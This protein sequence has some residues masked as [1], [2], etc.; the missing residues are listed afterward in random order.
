VNKL[1]KPLKTMPKTKEKTHIRLCPGQ[2]NP[3]CRSEL[4]HNRPA[5]IPLLVRLLGCNSLFRK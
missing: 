3:Y 2:K 5:L 1:I 4:L